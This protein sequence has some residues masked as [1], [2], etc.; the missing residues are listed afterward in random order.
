MFTLSI[1]LKVGPLRFDFIYVK[2]I[3]RS[4]LSLL[5]FMQTAC[6]QIHSSLREP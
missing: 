4:I 3:T 5:N 2:F 1:G 6:A